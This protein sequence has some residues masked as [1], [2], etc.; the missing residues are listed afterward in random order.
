MPPTRTSY[1]RVEPFV[2]RDGSL[3]RELMHPSSHAARHQSLAEALVPPGHATVLHEHRVTEEVYHFTGGKGRMR[4]ADDTFD[5]RKGDTVVIPP[6]TPHKLWN[7]DEATQALALL[8]AC[9]PAYAHEDTFLLEDEPT[10]EELASAREARLKTLL[11]KR[12]PGAEH[13]VFDASCH[14]VAEASEASGAPIDAFVKSVAFLDEAGALIVAIL[15]GEDRAAPARVAEAAGSQGALRMCPAL[16]LL[17]RT[18]YP[19]GGTPPLGYD[20]KFLM[21]E[22]VLER[23]TV[24]AGGGT[25]R[26]LMRVDPRALAKANDGRI[27]HLRQ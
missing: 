15:K 22:R 1:A 2:T 25:D 21:D 6:N 8:C 13:I 17:A 9:S 20:A 23:D 18:G 3:V 19:A 7:D 11:A 5:V 10:P 16:D 12:I 27:A 26:A 14:S 4:L 24:W